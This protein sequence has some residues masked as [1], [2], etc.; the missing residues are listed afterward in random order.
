VISNNGKTLLGVNHPNEYETVPYQ[1][2]Q[3]LTSDCFSVFYLLLPVF[4]WCDHNI[5]L[6]IKTKQLYD[7]IKQKLLKTGKNTE[8][9][10]QSKQ[11][12]VLA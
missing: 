4:A 11:C 1:S 9:N 6:Q 3:K 5:V 2:S 12:Q 8:I 10:K 7:H